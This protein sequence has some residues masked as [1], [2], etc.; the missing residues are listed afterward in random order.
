M[1]HF[2]LTLGTLDV[3]PALQGCSAQFLLHPLF[4]GLGKMHLPSGTDP[5]MAILKATRV[6]LGNNNIIIDGPA[7]SC[8]GAGGR[9]A[10]LSHSERCPIDG[11]GAEGTKTI[12]GRK[13][14]KSRPSFST[15]F[16]VADRPTIKVGELKVCHES[17]RPRS[18][19]P[20]AGCGGKD[21]YADDVVHDVR[22]R[23]EPSQRGD[24]TSNAFNHLS[25]S[26]SSI[27]ARCLTGEDARRFMLAHTYAVVV[28][29]Y[30]N[31]P[32]R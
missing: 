11:G 14:E 13:K 18:H 16:S 19:L 32:A 24:V 20:P 3:S 17:R 28:Y 25:V 7:E 30:A 29:I 9:R 10:D 5:V 21:G 31:G 1:L 12:A 6:A 22:S 8:G 27:E 4:V 15:F 23:G 26:F 2:T